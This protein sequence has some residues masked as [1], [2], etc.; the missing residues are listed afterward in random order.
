MGFNPF[1]PSRRG[2]ADYLLV[3]AAVVVSAALLLWAAGVL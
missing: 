1:R 2:P 3:A